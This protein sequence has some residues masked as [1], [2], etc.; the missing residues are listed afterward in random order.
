MLN[1]SCNKQDTTTNKCKQERKARTESYPPMKAHANKCQLKMQN[2]PA[3][4]TMQTKVVKKT[5]TNL[6]QCLPGTHSHKPDVI[7][8]LLSHVVAHGWSPGHTCRH[9][10]H[11]SQHQ[12]MTRGS[13]MQS[14]DPPQMFR[15]DCS[16]LQAFGG[17]Q[18]WGRYPQQIIK[19]SKNT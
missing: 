4:Q 17:F 9:V 3:I 15:L 1:N 12:S 5:K 19:S 8:F 10:R 16:H 7:N 14:G 13:H 6:P 18:K 2:E 11:Q